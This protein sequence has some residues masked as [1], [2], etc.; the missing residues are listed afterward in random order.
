MALLFLTSRGNIY[1]RPS[2]YRNSQVKSRVSETV[3]DCVHINLFIAYYMDSVKN[4]DAQGH[5]RFGEIDDF[6]SLRG[7]SESSYG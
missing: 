7:D 3:C 6:L 1:H 5:E 4:T 2:H